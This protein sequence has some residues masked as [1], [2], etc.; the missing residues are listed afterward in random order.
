VKPAVP[1]FY[2]DADILGLGKLVAGL[3]PD[4]TY[5]GDPG[6]EIHKRQRP[7]C[8]IDDP[9]TLDTIW[10]PAV[11]DAGML[12]IT[13]DNKIQEHRAEIQ[14]VKDA[15][16]RMIALA[17]TEA[18]G[19]WDQAE[20]LFSQW[21]AIERRLDESGPFIYAATRTGLRSVTLD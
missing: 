4:C 2:F 7:P 14:A 10:I 12:I 16:A 6:R 13:R 20:I 15:G 3:R 5:P 9:Q 21:R 11:T 1:R 17:G 19:T 18:V 8:V